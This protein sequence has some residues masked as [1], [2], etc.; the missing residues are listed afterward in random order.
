MKQIITAEKL[1]EKSQ[2]QIVTH[3]KKFNDLP[4]IRRLELDAYA[5][6]ANEIIDDE[7]KRMVADKTQPNP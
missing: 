4:E 6:W 1:H 2:Q 5:Q 3:R 7:V